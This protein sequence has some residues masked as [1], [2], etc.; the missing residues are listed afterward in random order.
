M[1]L[2]QRLIGFRVGV[3]CQAQ[4]WL[5]VAAL[6]MTNR[7]LQSATINAA[8]PALADVQSACN[9]AANG[10]TVN[11]P[12]GTATWTTNLNI[13]KSINL[14]GAGTDNTVIIDEVNRSYSFA[15]LIKWSAVTNA[16]ARLS[17]FTFQGGVTNTGVNF[18]GVVAVGGTCFAFREDHCYFNQL[19]AT[20]NVISGW[21]NGV[22]DH[23]TN[24]MQYKQAY[25]VWHNAFNGVPYG[26]GSWAAPS[27][28]GTSNCFFIEDNAFKENNANTPGAIDNMGGSRLV[29]RH[30]AFTN[31][32]ATT[33]GT[34][35]TGRERSVRHMEVYNNIYVTD[36][37]HSTTTGQ[38]RGGT[39][40]IFSNTYIGPYSAGMTLTC[41]RE[42]YAFTYWGG[43]NGT[44]GWDSNDPTLYASG[45]HTG[46]SG[47]TVLSTSGTAWTANQWVGYVLYNVAS[48][49]ASFITGNGASTITYDTDGSS[50]TGGATMAFNNGDVF[51][52]RK[53]LVA[54]DQPGRGQG[55]LISGVPPVPVA[56]PNQ[57]LEP[58]YSW[59]NTLNGAD[60]K[61][62]S[63][64]PTV[65]ENRDFFNDTVKPGYVP[66]TYPHPLVSGTSPPSPPTG[67][68]V[69]GGG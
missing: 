44:N 19:Y 4:A 3:W 27:S 47:A 53:V 40:V 26:D 39:G 2:V 51:Q 55:N 59:G 49:M 11:V 45:T 34:E 20:Y 16:P 5:L 9:S 43:A 28:M 60:V 14:I 48:G 35:S 67:L 69:V 18:N 50:V 58:I 62:G 22:A 13:T 41:Y 32:N 65:Q 23:N 61:I 52:I 33:H 6:L 10:D 8:T 24:V 7:P 30:N 12:A 63:G 64:Y 31:C 68:R 25:V 42:I 46:A 56:W 37:S 38:Y 57:A 21:I 1:V 17:G 36:N 15:G 66:Y 29:V 54:L